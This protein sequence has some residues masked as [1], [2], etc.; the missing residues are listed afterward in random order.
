MIIPDCALGF[1]GIATNPRVF[2]TPMTVERAIA[3]VESWLALSHVRLLLPGPRHLEL[4]FGL[5]RKLGLCSISRTSLDEFSRL[6]R[7]LQIS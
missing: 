1:V 4:A 5:L 7:A 2:D 3:C 6:S